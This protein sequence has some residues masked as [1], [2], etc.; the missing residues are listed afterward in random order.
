MRTL[1]W[2]F[3][4]LVSSLS[5]LS[6]GFVGASG[7]GRGAPPPNETHWAALALPGIDTP[8]VSLGLAEIPVALI[9]RASPLSHAMTHGPPA[10]TLALPDWNRDRLLRFGTLGRVIGYASIPAP[11]GL[12]P[13]GTQRAASPGRLRNDFADL[14]FSVRG[15]A[16][17]GGD[18][19][20]FRPCDEAV[21]LTCGVPLVP[22]ITPDIVFSATADGTVA[23][24]MVVDV[25]YEQ[26][27]SFEG[28]NRINVAYQGRPGEVLQRLEIG[29]VSFELP[30][31]RFLL[32]G[33]PAGAFGFQGEMQI[34]PVAVSSVWA[35]QAGEVTTRRFRLG[36]AD[37]GVLLSDTIVLDDADYLDGQF[38]FLLDPE[39]IHDYPHIDV[40][41]LTPSD[42]DALDAPG[43]GPIQLYR[44][45]IDP[46]A[47]Q[48]VEGHIL[49]DAIAVLGADTVV[50]S[51]WFRYLQPGRDYLVHPSG[52]WVAL[53][54]PLL[55]DEMLAVT[56]IAASGDTVGSYNPEV[57]Y[58]EGGRPTL[59]LLKASAGRHRPGLPTAS[60]RPARWTLPRSSSRSPLAR[61]APGAPS[62][63]ARMARR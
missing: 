47:Q 46:Y 19:S 14:G 50:E 37:E 7:Q 59:R 15:T 62:R 25:D 26:T 17:L 58:S 20:S 43:G 49:A 54:S 27:R 51:A 60:P 61:R 6:V 18:W 52:L 28:A 30:P 31:S 3:A 11:S 13:T 9:S 45:E 4:A 1:S 23:D 12:A 55:A 35:Q 63:A 32:E 48:Q 40:L 24:R 53:R 38:F 8:T 29:D 44:S 57:V 41:A 36:A 34:G 10:A 2:L 22:R 33:I 56:Y 16:R 42:S 21:Q 5:L 39:R